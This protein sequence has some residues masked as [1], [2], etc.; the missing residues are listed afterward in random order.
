M[1]RAGFP[2]LLFFFYLLFLFT[3][4]K[5][6]GSLGGSGLAATRLGRKV[7]EF[8]Y[9]FSLFGC[10]KIFIYLSFLSGKGNSSIVSLHSFGWG[11]ERF[12]ILGFR[13]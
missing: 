3:G 13:L 10:D 4:G 12:G 9:R 6:R 8:E 11:E 2:G 7:K 5:G 1:C